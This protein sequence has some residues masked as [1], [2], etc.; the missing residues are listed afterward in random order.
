M[1]FWKRLNRL[2]SEANPHELFEKE[3]EELHLRPQIASL[4]AQF[5]PMAAAVA[6]AEPRST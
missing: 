6:Q 4:L 2:K 1:K 3:R 5:M